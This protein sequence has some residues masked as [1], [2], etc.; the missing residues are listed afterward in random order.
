MCINL[1]TIERQHNLGWHCGKSALGGVNTGGGRY[2]LAGEKSVL[3]IVISVKTGIQSFQ[4]VTGLPVARERWKA[5]V[6]A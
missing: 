6:L 3:G 2:A 1:V 5:K 4:G